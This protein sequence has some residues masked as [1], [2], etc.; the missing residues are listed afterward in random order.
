LR[1]GFGKRFPELH[2]EFR[3]LVIESDRDLLEEFVRERR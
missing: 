3:G 1:Y 2:E